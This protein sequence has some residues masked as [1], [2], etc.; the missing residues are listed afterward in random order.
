MIR[1]PDQRFPQA[2]RGGDALHAHAAGTSRTGTGASHEAAAA[3]DARRHPPLP[4]S[5]GRTPFVLRR[6]L[7]R[8]LMIFLDETKMKYST[9]SVEHSW[10]CVRIFLFIWFLA[11]LCVSRPTCIRVLWPMGRA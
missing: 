1:L 7:K 9:P 2:A 11:Y 5:G 3:A 10:N 8:N 4:H 6:H